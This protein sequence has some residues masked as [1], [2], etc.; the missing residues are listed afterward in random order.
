MTVVGNIALYYIVLALAVPFVT[1][2][3]FPFWF[4]FVACEYLF[5]TEKE[6]L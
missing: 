2:F 4:C 3:F 6:S 1:S 5:F